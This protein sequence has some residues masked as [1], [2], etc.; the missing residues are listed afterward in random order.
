MTL[1][2][3]VGVGHSGR[4]SSRNGRGDRERD[5]ERGVDFLLLPFWRT[6]FCRL[7]SASCFE[8]EVQRLYIAGGGHA[9]DSGG[10]K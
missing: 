10:P 2:T 4:E 6:R 3:V 8:D 9:G 7:P 5:Q 1:T